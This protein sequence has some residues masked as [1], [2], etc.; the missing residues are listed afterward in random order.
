MRDRDKQG[1]RLLQ[2]LLNPQPEPEPFSDFGDEPPDSEME[3]LWAYWRQEEEEL[4][5]IKANRP[6]GSV[7]HREPKSLEFS[8]VP[9]PVWKRK[10]RP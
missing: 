6:L 10:L 2:N 8:K 1:R 5:A 4:E 9:D 7:V 3:E